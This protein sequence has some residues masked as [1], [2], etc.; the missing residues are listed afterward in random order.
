[1]GATGVVNHTKLLDVDQVD[2]PGP[3]RVATLQIQYPLRT[4]RK[5][6]NH[7][8]LMV[9]AI[10]LFDSKG[11]EETTLESIAKKAGLHVQTLYLHF[12]SKVELATAIWHDRLLDFESFFT[13]RECDAL[14]A[15]RNWVEQN[16]LELTLK[17]NTYKNTGFW[18]I[19]IISSSTQQFSHRYQEVLTEG[20]AQDMLAEVAR[21]PL[22]MLIA[23]M[24]LAGNE[25]AV[26]NWTNTGSK[27]DLATVLLNVIDTVRDQFQHL[28][29]N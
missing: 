17:S 14:N 13:A 23:T 1:M 26:R 4:K 11:Y 9:A 7:T 8:N 28:L 22:P 21:E 19:P 15:W 20:I 2:L 25:Q 27:T 12:P 6:Q 10:D 24:L 16:A 29:A 18:K 5:K 3:L